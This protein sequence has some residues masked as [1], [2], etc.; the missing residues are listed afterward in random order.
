MIIFCAR[1][2]SGRGERHQ[3][4]APRDAAAL[5]P[6]FF[7]HVPCGPACSR[8][9]SRQTL[10][11]WHALE[12]RIAPP[13]APTAGARP[14]RTRQGYTLS[15]HARHER[16]SHTGHQPPTH[17]IQTRRRYRRS[18]RH[19]KIQAQM[20]KCE[21]QVLMTTPRAAAAEAKMLSARLR[22]Q[23]RAAEAS[24]TC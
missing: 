10:A 3:R 24:S 6:V 18:H 4:T 8:V 14:D 9:L 2:S 5:C 7:L 15:R 12:N 11:L 1:R 23:L 22:R 16:L 13:P 20:S 21:V 17:A 19:I